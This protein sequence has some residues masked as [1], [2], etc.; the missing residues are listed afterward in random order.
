VEPSQ[1][2]LEPLR[3]DEEFALYR[4]E[5]SPHPPEEQARR[6]YERTWSLLGSRAIEELVD[7]PLMSDALSLATQDVL[8]K[9]VP[10]ALFTE[11]NLL[12]LLICRMVNLTL[13]HGNSDGSCFAYVSLG[14][15][16]GP[17]FDNHEGGFQFGRLGYALYA[18]LG[19][20][21]IPRSVWRNMGRGGSR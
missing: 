3:T 19:A 6:E 13:E 1:L 14:M 18:M 2:V 7:L 17:H 9:V 5:H 10:P 8:A 16:A 4:G 21:F 20:L 12:S 15:I 11:R